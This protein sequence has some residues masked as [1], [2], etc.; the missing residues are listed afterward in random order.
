MKRIIFFTILVVSQ[1][2]LYSKTVSARLMPFIG[3]EQLAST[4]GHFVDENGMVDYENLKKNSE[5]LNAYVD[6]IVNTNILE[7]NENEKKV[8]WI[9][10]YNAITLK[11]I[12]DHY[13]VKS[14]RFINFGLVWKM[15]KSV[16]HGQYSLG[17]IEHKLL[18]KM[19]DPRI[20]FAINCASI[21][22]P[23]L[24][25]KPFYP[26]TID[27][28]LDEQAKRFINDTEKVRLDRE[29]NILYYSAIFDWF[30]E[31]F[32][33]DEN[34]ILNYIKR[35]INKADQEYLDANEVTLKVLKYDWGLNKQ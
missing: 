33:S 20:H 26:N 30:K 34:S 11:T 3:Y 17:D 6:S 13:P 25:N 18:R 35:Y 21:G 22:C 15:P 29:N 12:V 5:D 23:R 8:F 7:F 2:L 9:N 32:L 1:I 10:A 31:D 4:L 28:Q 24:S 19:G 27:E 14:I 16:A